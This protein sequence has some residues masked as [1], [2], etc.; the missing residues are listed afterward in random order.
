MR[1][2]RWQAL[3]CHFGIG[4]KIFGARC[5]PK[6]KEPALVGP[7]P[8]RLSLLGRG[9]AAAASFY[10]LLQPG[11]LEEIKIAVRNICHADQ[12]RQKGKFDTINITIASSKV[13]PM[14][15]IAILAI[16]QE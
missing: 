4:D 12:L 7:A 15:N 2:S 14:P 3:E 16:L 1:K 9:V 8:V 6:R 10:T 13:R 5:A 11:F